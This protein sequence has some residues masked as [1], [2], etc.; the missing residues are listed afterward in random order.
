MSG[1]QLSPDETSLDFPGSS[2]NLGSMTGSYRCWAEI[3]AEALRHNVASIRSL[4][5]AGV[6]IMSV[7]KAD[8][9][10]HGLT[11]VARILDR[12]IDLFGVA[13]LKEAEEIRM[14]GAGSEVVILSPALP[15]ERAKIVAGRFIPT[16][17]TLEEASAYAR[18]IVPGNVF[19]I[20]FVID[21]GMGRMGLSWREAQEII[22]A[23][24]KIPELRIEA[25]SSHL[26]VADEDTAYTAE[27]LAQF[28]KYRLDDTPATVLNGAGVLAFA[29]YATSG[30]IVRVGLP[31]YGIS[32][33]MEFQS[34][35][36]PAL[37][38]KT[39]V[40]LVRTL[41]PG[42][43]ISYGRTFIT[44]RTM[45]VATLGAG[46]GDGIDRHLSGQGT[47]VLIGGARC[48]LLGRVTMDQIMVDVSHLE[49]V[50]P[51]DEVVLIGRQGGQ[52]ILATEL[53]T[54]AGTITWEIFTG[55]TRRVDRD[56]LDIRPCSGLFLNGV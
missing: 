26:P 33:L 50:A 34:R 4:V 38:L 12:E 28:S 29:R 5:S 11:G 16:I 52:E 20:H 10:G 3:D 27:Q 40:T 55:I 30:D 48:A 8:A 54:K 22:Q 41:G 14:A 47:E 7:V 23:I 31:L 42:R 2:F 51:G 13:C 24:K 46:Y 37:T 45:K 44:P 32:P 6:K 53:A 39:R 35:F 25:L 9:Y 18:C 1:A 21:T 15:N 17:S 36:R 43:S 56:Y 49:S 19:P